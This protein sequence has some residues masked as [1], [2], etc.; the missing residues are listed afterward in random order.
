MKHRLV[1]TVAASRLLASCGG[2]GSGNY[3]APMTNPGNAAPASSTPAMTTTILGSPGLAT[4]NGSTLY[5]FSG[6]GAGVSNCNGS[7]ASIW[8]P[9]MATAG[10]QAMGSFTV[11]MRS[12]GSH[13]WAFKGHPLYTFQSDSKPGMAS[14]QGVTA[15]GGTFTVARP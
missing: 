1:A 7:C 9:F 8:P 12:D 6:D 4:P 11:I 10:A 14:G 3:N 15:D 5:E 2:Y 13:Q